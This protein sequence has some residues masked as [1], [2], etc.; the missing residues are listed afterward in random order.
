MSLD[1]NYEFH[2]AHK[3]KTMQFQPQNH[4]DNGISYTH[5]LY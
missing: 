2:L 5:V 3:K 1:E 4:Y